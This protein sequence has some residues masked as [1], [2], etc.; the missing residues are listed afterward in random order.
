[1]KKGKCPTIPKQTPSSFEESV[2]D[3]LPVE[4]QSKR[5]RRSRQ[6]QKKKQ[7]KIEESEI[8]QYLDEMVAKAATEEQSMLLEEEKFEANHNSKQ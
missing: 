4:W 2:V 5:K 6:H 8:D 1:M 3:A 7:I